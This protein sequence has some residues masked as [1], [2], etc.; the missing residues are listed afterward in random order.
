MVNSKNR[1]NSVDENLRRWEEM[2]KASAEGLRNSVRA[3]ID[4]QSKNGTLRDPVIY[5]CNLQPH[6]RT[7]YARIVLSNF[8]TLSFDIQDQVQG[9][10]NLR[11]R[12]S[13][14]G[15]R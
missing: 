8:L 5:R 13:Y 4:M 6:H 15:Q 2:K 7:G 9:L 11:F 12:M 3:K 10:P 14:C 1:D